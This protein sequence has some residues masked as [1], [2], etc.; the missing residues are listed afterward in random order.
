LLTWAAPSRWKR[1]RILRTCCSLYPYPDGYPDHPGTCGRQPRAVGPGQHARGAG[2]AQE[3]LV[4]PPRYATLESVRS[5]HRPSMG[6]LRRPTPGEIVEGGRLGR[7]CGPGAHSRASQKARLRLRRQS[8][9]HLPYQHIPAWLALVR[10]D[11]HR[12]PTGRLGHRND[13]QPCHPTP[14]VWQAPPG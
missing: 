12:P 7:P 2:H 4:T 3:P 10:P 8:H 6:L 5:I 9:I 14:P 13:P 1:P 11:A